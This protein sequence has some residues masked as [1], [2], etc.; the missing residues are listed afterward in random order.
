MEDHLWRVSEFDSR[1]LS[2][3]SSSRLLADAD[4]E[5]RLGIH[6]A[7]YERTDPWLSEWR[8]DSSLGP[9]VSLLSVGDI[10]RKQ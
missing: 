10:G 1:P 9:E 3:V 7:I 6:E 2:R 4:A 8:Y 5:K